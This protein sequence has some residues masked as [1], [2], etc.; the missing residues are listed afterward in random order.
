[1]NT[2]SSPAAQ[3]LT[4]GLRRKQHV[5]RRAI[6]VFLSLLTLVGSIGPAACSS[7]VVQLS[8]STEYPL[9]L[10]DL[11]GRT[12]VLTQKPTRIV[13]T[14][15]TATETLYR[16]GGFAVGRDTAST[17]PEEVESL[18]TVGGSYTINAEAVAGLSP[19]LIVI[20]AL[21][22]ASLVGTLQQIGVPIIAVRAASLDDIGQSLT[23]LGKIVDADG[24]AAQAIADIQGRI[25]NITAAAPGG[26]NT[27]IFIA[28]AQKNV[29][30][31]KP[32]SYPG[33]VASLLKLGNLAAGLPESGPYPGF[34]LFTAEQATQSNP[35][36][37][38]A[39]TPAPLLFLQAAGPRIADAAESLL[40]ITKTQ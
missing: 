33:T 37:V 4:D 28:D 31:A 34:A 25:E 6:T 8:P 7:P 35:D 17:Y 15:P 16:S 26:K 11:L 36:L 5:G 13:T 14:H 3:G 2:D 29:Y 40:N 21:T 12:V 24:R 1:M 18:R 39:I 9:T 22:Q 30:A 10:T 20:E 27:L 32:E 38:F 19:D 23:L